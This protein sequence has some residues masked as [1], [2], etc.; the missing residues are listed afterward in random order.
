MHLLKLKLVGAIGLAACL[1]WPAGAVEMED[2]PAYLTDSHGAAGVA[3]AFLEL[4][5]AAPEYDKYW[6]GSLDWLISVAERD[7][8]G[9]IYWYM[10]T[11]APKGHSSHRISIPGTCHMIR[12]F[13]AGYER[14]GDPRYR[15]TA[16]E[17]TRTLLERFARQRQT[18]YG[19]AYGWS[20][21][22]RPND[23][24]LGLLAGHSHGLGNL[25]STLLDA[26]EAAPAGPLKADVK[27]ALE[28]IL[29][30]LR[31]RGVR[32][33]KD[34]NVLVSWPT[35][36]NP[37]VIE[38]G[39]CYGQAGL[40]LPL[41]RMAEVLPE[42]ELPDG[43]TPLSLANGNLWYL[44]S[45]AREARG[46][47]VWPYMRHNQTSKNIGYGSGTGGIGWAFLRGAQVNGDTDPDF[48]S[49]C[50]KYAKGAAV[51]AVGLIS[52]YRPKGPMPG[53]GGDAGFGVCGGAGGAGHFLM[54]YA[55]EV[56][57]QDAALAGRIRAA[58]LR[59][60]QAV[61]ASAVE[62]GDGTM[63]CP[64]RFHF[65]RVNIA[66]DYGQT[67]VAFGLAVAGKYLQNEDLTTAAKKV[68]DYIAKRAVPEG[69]GLKFAQFHPLP[70]QRRSP[71]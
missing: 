12:V 11:T 66:L 17:G 34:G 68:A 70:N 14:C 16:L 28:G 67:G 52:N 27:R 13:L 31:L 71:R 25:M 7:D 35:L 61:L 23:R 63:V 33:E 41:L 43:T 60:S 47:C 1:S 45:V 18:E 62:L 49:D 21:A 44:M 9:R 36:K 37:K 39:Y 6:K 50:M 59:V 10:S 51:F 30:N 54:L 48:A 2:G 24:S 65:K 5:E 3:H 26:Y 53:P 57:D 58:C 64:D 29:V 22:Y 20:H 42:L 8:A 40:A 19:T 4:S 32:T 38:T 69:G 15:E 46:G 55:E 56:G